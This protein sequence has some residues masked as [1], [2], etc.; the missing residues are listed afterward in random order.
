MRS[1]QPFYLPFGG[2][3]TVPLEICA[4]LNKQQH[5][6]F[7][8]MSMAK[9]P[10]SFALVIST[11]TCTK[12]LPCKF[13]MA[14]ESLVRAG[15]CV[16]EWGTVVS[17]AESETVLRSDWPCRFLLMALALRRNNSQLPAKVD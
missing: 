7:T 17:G 3:S 9:Y 5:A 10:P 2:G 6:S 1:S 12:L 13:P 14:Q 16:S 15:R 11:S 8:V 4:G